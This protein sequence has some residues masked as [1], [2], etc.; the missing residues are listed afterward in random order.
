MKILVADD[1]GLFRDG[2]RMQLQ[3]ICPDAAVFEA[4]TYA[5]ARRLIDE[6]SPDFLLMDLNMPGA[7]WREELAELVGRVGAGRCVVVS[8]T[9]DPAVI[10]EAMEMGLAGFVPKRA[11]PKIVAHALSLVFD[12]GVYVPP[13]YMAL[14]G[15]DRRTAE[16]DPGARPLTPRQMDVLRGIC[17]GHSNKQIAYDLTMSEATVKQHVNAVLKALGVH[18]RTEAAMAAQRQGLLKTD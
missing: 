2:I 15:H 14:A 1:H 3:R 6:T 11:E 18:N 12:G 16:G 13:E 4:G 7:H 5:D 17:A 10:A 9:E 8:A